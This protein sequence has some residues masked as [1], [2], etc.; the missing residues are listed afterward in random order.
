MGAGDCIRSILSHYRTAEIKM[1]KPNSLTMWRCA[2]RLAP[3]LLLALLLSACAAAAP[4]AELPPTAAPAQPAS[5]TPAPSATDAPAATAEPTA[6]AA[7]SATPEPSPT[8]EPTQANFRV[9]ESDGMEQIFIPA[10]EFTMGGADSAAQQAIGNGIA[11][12]EVPVHKVTLDSFWIDKYEVTNRQYA[13]CVAAGACAP[14][15]W[16]AS[17]SRGTYFSNPEYANYPVIYVSWYQARDYCAWAGRRLLS[18]AE[19]E[20]A[21]RGDDAR[22]YPWGNDPISGDKANFCDK[23]CPRSFANMGFDDGYVE[24]APVGSFPAGASAYGVMDMAGNVWEWTNTVLSLYPYDP[25]DGRESPDA[26]E[27]RMW[28]GGAWSTGVWYMR[29]STRY[30]SVQKY[31]YHNLGIRCGSSN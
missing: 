3:V 6:T 21:A 29:A 18:E 4:T 24:T 8:L 15:K 27:Q 30:H 2:L 12:P 13:L 25:N 5:P 17:K 7:P 23:N 1:S 22:L 31:Q 19:W 10:G 14:P 9:A 11:Y 26:Y 16:D 20:K 28:R